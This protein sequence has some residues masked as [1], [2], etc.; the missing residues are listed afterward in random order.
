MKVLHTPILIFIICLL[1]PAVVFSGSLPAAAQGTGPAT[2][3]ATPTATSIVTTAQ[4]AVTAVQP[5]SAGN[6][7][8]TELVVTGSGF[9]DGAVVVLSGIGGLDTTFVSSSLLRAILPAEVNPGVYSLTVINPDAAS[10]TLANA[11][12]I[13]GQAAPTR[14][15]KPTETPAPTAFVRPLLVVNSY[16]ASS[17]EIT[18]GE[19]LDFEM[20]I[21][22]AGQ[23]QASN[24]VVTFVSGSFI[25]RDTG[26]VRALG[27]LDP[28]QSNRFWQPLNASRDLS[29]QTIGTLEVKV[30]YTDVNGTSYNET[31]ALTFPIVRVSSGAAATD[32][33][34]PTPTPTSTN[35]PVL[36]PQLIVTTYK[37]DVQQ[38][39]PG[40]FFTLLLTVQN[41]GN[42]DARRVTMI[43]GGGNTG[44]GTIDGTPVPGGGGVSGADGEF[45]KFAPVNT[46]NVLS[47]GDLAVS[48]TLTAQMALIVNA[49]TDPGAYPVKV[50]F[51]YNDAAN[52]DYVD[53]QVITL[54]VIRRP[55]VEMDFYAPPP[56]FFAGESGSLPL[57][58]VNSGTKSMVFGNFSVTTLQ[59]G[60]TFENASL[61]V[62]NLEP[63]G[64]YPLDAIIYPEMPGSLDLLLNV[65][66]TDDFNQQQTITK[67]LTVEV[68][69]PMV[70]EEPI[71]PF[72]GEEGVPLPELEPETWG[73][74]IWRFLKGLLG[75]SSGLPQPLDGG[76]APGMEEP[77]PGEGPVGPVFG[78]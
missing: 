7:V 53:D 67:T 32:T 1:L 61:F 58:L 27:T 52:G 50:S 64:F 3:T 78:P 21:G 66:Y 8:P 69:E 39:Q 18:P 68:M 55:S 31:F 47:L 10:V 72:P 24:I 43:L 49:T 19:N 40:Q 63:G 77:F 57:Q 13:T 30:A 75:L 17:S 74:K 59:G 71:E 20:T 33:P 54:L 16:G 44:G 45:S 29:G 14:T 25:P 4:L 26:G 23:T 51:V 2:D 76:F 38:L 65:D 9:A 35:G 60:A 12:T 73:D 42:A 36:R 70:F 48:G 34:T 56:P 62:G 46:S 41:Q 37:T 5:N 15:P 6:S 22:N 28:G 11:L